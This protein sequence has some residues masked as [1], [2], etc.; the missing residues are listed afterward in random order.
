MRVVA[1]GADYAG[2]LH[3]ALRE[4]APLK[5]LALNFAI[6]VIF[7]VLEQHGSMGVQKALARQWVRDQRAR[8]GMARCAAFHLCGGR[9]P[10]RPHPS[11]DAARV[12]LAET[13]GTIRAITQPDGKTAMRV[14][15]AYAA[16]C[17]GNMRRPRPMAAFATDADFR[18]C[19][20][21]TVLHCVIAALQPG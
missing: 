20:F 8:S 4:G 11:R 14:L 10:W 21:I 1:I 3:P 15:R 17:P 12:I 19:C 2:A 16:L 5:H 7:A 6:G 13:P 9:L 18:P